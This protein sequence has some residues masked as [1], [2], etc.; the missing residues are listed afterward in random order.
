MKLHTSI[1]LGLLLTSSTMAA[2]CF[3]GRPKKDADYISRAGE[4]CRNCHTRGACRFQESSGGGA[5]CKLN[6]PPNSVARYCD[7]GLTVHAYR[8]AFRAVYIYIYISRYIC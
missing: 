3:G 5:Y 1:S 6:I 8:S 2:N 7:V 4:V